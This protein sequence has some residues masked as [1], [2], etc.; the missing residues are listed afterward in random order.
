MIVAAAA[1]AIAG[2]ATTPEPNYPGTAA[3]MLIGDPDERA[4]GAAAHVALAARG[5]GFSSDDAVIT[6]LEAIFA[7]LV[8]AADEDRPL[9]YRVHVIDDLL[10]AH[11]FSTPGGHVYVTSGLLLQATSEAEVAAVLAHELGHLA[12]RHPVQRVVASLGVPEAA[13]LSLRTDEERI[14]HAAE[15][16]AREAPRLAHTPD[17]EHLAD[18]RGLKYAWRGGW[19]ATAMVGLIVHLSVREG[20]APWLHL[21]PVDAVRAGH[22]EKVVTQGGYVGGRLGAETLEAIQLHLLER[23][24]VSQR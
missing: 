23:L 17:Q 20:S 8:P 11:A 3:D 19:D 7:R 12:A 14:A 1:L 21:H 15:V 24:P 5:V 18:T 9:D 6:Y 13:A 4:V 22:I 16:V 2:C 10:R